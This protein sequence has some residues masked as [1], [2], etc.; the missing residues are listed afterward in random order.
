MNELNRVRIA[1]VGHTNAGKTSLIRTLLRR[2]VGEVADRSNVTQLSESQ[3]FQDLFAVLVD[4]PGFQNAAAYLIYDALLKTHGEDAASLVETNASIDYERQVVETLTSVDACIYVA[5]LEIV[6]DDTILKEVELVVQMCPRTLVVLNKSRELANQESQQEA[7]S[8][9]ELWEKEALGH[10]ARDVVLFD[11]HWSTPATAEKFLRTLSRVLPQEK[12]VLLEAGVRQFIDRQR[13]LR[14][15]TIAY[16]LECIIKC[17]KLDLSADLRGRPG[18]SDQAYEERIREAFIKGCSD[19]IGEFLDRANALYEL[20]AEWPEKSLRDLGDYNSLVGRM[21]KLA[22]AAAAATV[23][24]ALSGGIGALVGLL[25]SVGGSGVVLSTAA[26]GGAAIG[27]ATGGALAGFIGLTGV[28]NERDKLYAVQSG[29]V[30]MLC[31]TAVWMFS[32]Y[33]WGK[34]KHIPK[35]Y[36]AALNR[37]MESVAPGLDSINWH[38][39]PSS[40]MEDWML[41]CLSSISRKGT[42]EPPQPAQDKG[43]ELNS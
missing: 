29:C 31:L 12:K 3:D 18:E 39:A 16:A 22:F 40:E 2:P 4:T 41:R 7:D 23:V 21:N 33:G 5:S 32:C 1:V 26:G 17:R 25:L 43:K 24:G 13:E 36:F 15:Q 38:T 20:A 27:S 9:A 8:R 10:G 34:G 28:Q 35:E 37:R 11:A 42:L 30:A 14:Q 19:Q 6:P